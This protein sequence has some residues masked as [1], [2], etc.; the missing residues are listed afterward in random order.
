MRPRPPDMSDAGSSLLGLARRIRTLR[1]RR[2]L[3]QE[4]FAARCDISVSFVSLLER[5]E[6]NPSYDTLLQVAAALELPL[7]ELFR[8][9][10]AEDAEAHRLVDWV[11]RRG[12]GREDVDRLLAVAEA[13][14]NGGPEALGSVTRTLSTP[15]CTAPECGRP[16]LARGLCT[17]HYHR[18]RRK[19][20]PPGPEGA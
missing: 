10:D 14:F 15:G 11:R 17:A 18:A 12:L 5:G 19:K 20:A 13:M 7:G 1:E 4:D 8:L 9:E 2:G 6:R 3:T 16:V